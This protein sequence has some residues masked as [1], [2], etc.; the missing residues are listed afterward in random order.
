LPSLGPQHAVAAKRD[1]QALSGSGMQRL[2]LGPHRLPSVSAGRP[3]S[4]AN[5]V[6]LAIT[7]S[8]R[9]ASRTT[10]SVSGAM[11][12][13]LHTPLPA[14]LQRRRD[15][16]FRDFHL[17]QQC[18]VRDISATARSASS[19]VTSPLAPGITAIMFSPSPP[20]RISAMP[21]GPSTWRTFEVGS[22][23]F[24]KQGK[25]LGGEGVIADRAA[26]LHR[27]SGPPRRQRLVGALAARRRGEIGS[28][29]GFAR[30]RQSRRG[31]DQV[32]VDGADDGDHGGLPCLPAFAIAAGLRSQSCR[33]LSVSLS[34]W[35][36]GVSRLHR[37]PAV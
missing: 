33:K 11:L 8:A 25:R 26:H 6:S 29:H 23:R 1:D 32:H 17:Q 18:V 22:G 19:A 34:V 30:F 36:K 28:G 35:R 24:T 15:R 14:P 13:T 9:G 2:D 20:T 5:S 10:A 21:V 16:R 31:S 37:Q 3:E 27:C 4:R 7:M 12:R